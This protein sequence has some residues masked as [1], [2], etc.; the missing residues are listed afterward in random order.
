M[1]TCLPAEEDGD[2][3][4]DDIAA[5]LFAAM[6]RRRGKQKQRLTKPGVDIKM[7]TCG[8]M[9]KLSVSLIFQSLPADHPSVKKAQ[10]GGPL[11]HVPVVS[12]SESDGLVLDEFVLNGEPY[13]VVG[14]DKQKG[15]IQYVSS[16]LDPENAP[17]L[18]MKLKAALKLIKK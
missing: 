12:G 10:D 15:T 7:C 5:S 11:K 17:Q 18:T 3:D 6:E 13:T 4:A 16:L 9:T 1:L 8:P 14:V 2:D